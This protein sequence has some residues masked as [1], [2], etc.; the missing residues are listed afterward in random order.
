MASGDGGGAVAFFDIDGTLVWRDFEALERGGS[1]KGVMG[2][3]GAAPTPGVYGAFRRMAERGHRAFICTGRPLCMIYPSLM[4]LE[5]AGIV[6]CAGAY[7]AVGDVVV[8]DERIEPELARRMVRLFAEQGV[9][10]LMESNERSVELCAPGEPARFPGSE[11][12]HSVGEMEDL[13]G[14]VGF[15]KFCAMGVDP[16]AL[17]RLR[18]EVERHFT[19]SDLQGGIYEF[20][21]VGVDKGTAIGA[22]LA[23]LGRGGDLAGTYAFGDSENDLSMAGAVGT[24]VA[25][26]NALPGVRAAADYVTDSAAEDGVVTGLEH[27]G[28]I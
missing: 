13:A 17:E 5:A 2:S 14:S 25:M 19:I 20:S 18:P 15:A 23:H 8:R 6:A 26:G 1:A 24:F 9:N 27:F 11:A 12:T 4:E 10:V 22:V 21:Q 3:F 28:V 7:A 16:A